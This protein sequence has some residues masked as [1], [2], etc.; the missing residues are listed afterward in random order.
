MYMKS[1]QLNTQISQSNAE[2]YFRRGGRIHYHAM[3][4]VNCA[5]LL[6]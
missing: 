3:H 6:Q 4:Y 1:V 2:M 5:V